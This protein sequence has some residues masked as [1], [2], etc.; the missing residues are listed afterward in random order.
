MKV[1]YQSKDTSM[2][3]QTGKSRFQSTASHWSAV[4]KSHCVWIVLFAM[5]ISPTTLFSQDNRS[6]PNTQK[7]GVI[8]T[9]ELKKLV[10]ERQDELEKSASAG[11]KATPQ[12]FVLVDVRSDREM[13]VSVIPTAVSKAEFEKNITEY[14][15]KV[16]IPYCTIGGRCGE[17]SKALAQA[18]WTVRSYRGS[19]VDWVQHELPLVTPKGK[20][21]DQLHTNG[22]NFN[23]PARYRAVEK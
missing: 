4:C 23:L 5:M 11:V 12:Q 22:G 10:T 2:K 21:T 14:K 6:A 8:E 7:I 1:H 16:V 19:I 13:A 17:F 15:G 9:D 18:G 20:P 3:F